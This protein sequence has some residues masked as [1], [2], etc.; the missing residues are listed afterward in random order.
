M[1]YGSRKLVRLP[2][3]LELTALKRS[4]FYAKVAQG[5]IPK[6]VRIDPKGKA[7]AWLEDEL[8]ALQDRAIAARDQT[9]ELAPAK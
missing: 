8:L 7:S 2:R 4:Q 5:I 3:A 6:P 9:D 1:N